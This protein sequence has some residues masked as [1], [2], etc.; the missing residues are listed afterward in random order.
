MMAGGQTASNEEAEVAEA[1]LQLQ[2][3]S[4]IFLLIASLSI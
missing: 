2:D 3:R 4:A 1:L